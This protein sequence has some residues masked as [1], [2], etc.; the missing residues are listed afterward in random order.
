M[1]DNDT[2]CFIDICFPE[3]FIE[4]YEYCYYGDCQVKH[5]FIKIQNNLATIEQINNKP[6]HI[7]SNCVL[8]CLSCNMKKKS[9]ST[10]ST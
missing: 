1:V 10:T 9:N 8:C 5:Q 2:D 4:D 7:K 3:G 6:G